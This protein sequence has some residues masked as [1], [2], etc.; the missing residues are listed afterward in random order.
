M[1]DVTDSREA[2]E[3]EGLLGEWVCV[4]KITE[5][6]WGY[7]AF[8]GVFALGATAMI[9]AAIYVEVGTSPSMHMFS[10]YL[11]FAA[12]FV[13]A[14]AAVLRAVHRREGAERVAL[15]RHSIFVDRTSR[16][17]WQRALDVAR[18]TSVRLTPDPPTGGAMFEVA[19]ATS[20]E[21]F[22][23]LSWADSD[24]LLALMAGD[25]TASDGVRVDDDR[26]RTAQGRGVL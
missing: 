13:L 16:G 2:L 24:R 6:Y 8:V 3:A 9:L 25:T 4:T 23:P 18:T 17:E 11:W 22:G 1:A 15:T 19:T 14:G 20:Y 5:A 7:V 12:I 21:T 26:P 10:A